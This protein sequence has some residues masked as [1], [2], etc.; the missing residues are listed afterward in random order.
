MDPDA[1]KTV[2]HV[3][4]WNFNQPSSMANTFTLSVPNCY[5]VFLPTFLVLIL[6]DAHIQLRLQTH[7]FCI[8]T[9]GAQQ[10]AGYGLPA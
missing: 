1:V 3:D 4:L 9:Q 7:C 2:G 10:V 8:H 5:N 6:E